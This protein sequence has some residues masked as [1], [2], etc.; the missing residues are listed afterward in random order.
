MGSNTLRGGALLMF[1]VYECMLSWC[2]ARGRWMFTS[3]M[4]HP[5]QVSPRHAIDDELFHLP[6]VVIPETF[7]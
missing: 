7:L 6:G 5:A 2:A 3:C 1:E 4:V